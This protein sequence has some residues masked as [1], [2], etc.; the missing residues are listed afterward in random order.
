[1]KGSTY[2]YCLYLISGMILVVGL[3]GA[4]LIYRAAEN[5]SVGDSDSAGGE[6]LIDPLNP[7]YSKQYLRDLERYGGQANVLAYEA[8][9]WWVGLWKGKSLAY[10]VA[11][12]AVLASLA[13]FY[14]ADH[15][16]PR[17]PD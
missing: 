1:M 15:L 16:S 11:C 2:A 7:E 5:Q 8:R 14:A 3:G 9:L 12:I 10:M 4:L 13:V 17:G 6:E